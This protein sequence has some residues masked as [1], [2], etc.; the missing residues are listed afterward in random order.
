MTRINTEQEGSGRAVQV[1][2][3]I[4]GVSEPLVRMAKRSSMYSMG[5]LAF[6]SSAINI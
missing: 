5:S 3:F 2:A 4:H 6:G 1:L